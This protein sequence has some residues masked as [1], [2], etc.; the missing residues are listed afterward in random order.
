MN[1]ALC[2]RSLLLVESFDL[3]PSSQYIL[4][5]VIPSCFRFAKMCLC[6]VS[7]PSSTQTNLDLQNTTLG[8]GF[9]F[10]HRNPRTLPMQSC[11]HDHGRTLVRAEYGYPKRF[12]HTN[13]YRR[14]PPLQLPIQRSPQ[15]TPKR[16]SSEPYGATR[17]Q[18]TIAK[19]PAK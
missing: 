16:P 7:L 1:D 13:S 14:N 9:H 10:Q 2:M 19:T 12:P 5:R 15:R 6:Q 11:V 17:Q 3:R 18:Q 4:V 8:Y